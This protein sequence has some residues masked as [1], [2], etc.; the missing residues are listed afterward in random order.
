MPMTDDDLPEDYDA[1][2]AAFIE[3]RAKVSGA[4]A[5]IALHLG[6]HQLKMRDQ[7][8]RARHFRAHLDEG[9]LQRVIVF[10]KVVVRHRHEVIRSQSPVIRSSHVAIS[11]INSTLHASY[12]SRDHAQPAADGRQL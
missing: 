12:Q 2:K 11:T 3:M 10:G 7:G 6:D 9:G 4:E 5:L 8:F 1:L